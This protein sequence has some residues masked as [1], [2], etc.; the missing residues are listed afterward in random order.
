[1]FTIYI[2][3]VYH[4]SVYAEINLGCTEL[5]VAP[6]GPVHGYNFDAVV[7]MYVVVPQTHFTLPRHCPMHIDGHAQQQDEA[8]AC[9]QK[10]GNL[11]HGLA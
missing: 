3:V 5:C 4:I 11:D 2:I 10:I 1:M 7:F 6:F 9:Y 8:E